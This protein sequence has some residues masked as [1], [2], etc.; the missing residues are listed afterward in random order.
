VEGVQ[1]LREEIGATFELGVGQPFLLEDQGDTVGRAPR[2]RGDQFMEAH[3]VHR[4]HAINSFM[5]SLEPA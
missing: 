5:I 4:E 3:V 2:L 1:M